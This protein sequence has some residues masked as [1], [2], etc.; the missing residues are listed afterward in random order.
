MKIVGNQIQITNSKDLQE[1]DNK[2]AQIE[3]QYAPFIILTLTT[4]LNEYIIDPIQDAMRNAGVSQK[5]IDRT[6]LDVHA[7]KTT[8]QI[9]FHIKSDYISESGFPVAKIIENGRRAY[10]I[11]P[12][13]KRFLAWL[14]QGKWHKALKVEMPIK[15]AGHYILDAILIGQPKVQQEVNIRTKEWL[16]KI[17]K[18]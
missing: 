13:K 9:V 5:V 8:N 16:N 12:N 1:L 10:T 7:E 2:V 4:I 17:L 18:S 14:D 6:Y 11:V 3:A 15:E